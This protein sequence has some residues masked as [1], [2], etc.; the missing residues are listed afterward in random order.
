MKM[1]EQK[2]EKQKTTINRFCCRENTCVLYI[3]I[4]ISIYNTHVFSLQ[5]KRLIVLNKGLGSA[6][7]TC[8]QQGS[9]KQ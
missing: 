9:G 7:L 3:Y 5:Q 4:Y 2:Q 6:S 8:L 1:E